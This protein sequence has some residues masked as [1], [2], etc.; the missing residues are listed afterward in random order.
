MVRYYKYVYYS[1]LWDKWNNSNITI[2]FNIGLIQI[3]IVYTYALIFV[4]IT[5]EFDYLHHVFS[6]VYGSTDEEIRRLRQF[7]GGL[8]KAARMGREQL[9]PPNH[10]DEA[11]PVPSRHRACFAAGEHPNCT[12]ITSVIAFILLATLILNQINN[13]LIT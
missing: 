2:G 6:N 10:E 11:C 5:I 13:I 8:L 4:H 7:S 12:I 3:W 9:L 1:I